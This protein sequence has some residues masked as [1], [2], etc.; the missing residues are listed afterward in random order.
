MSNV[1]TVVRSVRE[2]YVGSRKVAEQSNE[3]LEL[4]YSKISLIEVAGIGIVALEM[5]ADV[6]GD[7]ADWELSFRMRERLQQ[8][9]RELAADEIAKAQDEATA[10]IAE[11]FADIPPIEDPKEVTKIIESPNPSVNGFHHSE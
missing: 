6:L 5:L 11:P 10:A 1:A 9:M 2:W 7:S 3:G 4:F 8:L